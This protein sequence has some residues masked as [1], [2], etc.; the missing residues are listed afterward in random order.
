M[1]AARDR[2]GSSEGL[3]VACWAGH[4][5]QSHNHNDVGNFIVFVDGRP[6]II[7]IGKPTYTRQTFSADRYEIRS[8]QSAYHNLPTVNGAMQEAGRRYA[9]RAV[10]YESNED[11]A[12]LR[13]DIAPAYPDEAGIETW[14]RTVRL[15]R[16]KEIQVVDLFELKEKSRDI[17]Q[18][19][20]TPCE[21]IRDEPGKLV[22]RDPEKQT[23][24]TVQYDS[25]RLAVQIE[26]IR[27]D[28]DRLVA[29]WGPRL[30]RVLLKSKSAAKRDTWTL[31]FSK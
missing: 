16:G 17:V 11:Q 29:I 13:M 21:I 20:I 8:M 26:T 6:F 25:D 1:M 22:L 31:R 2:Q 9:A 5:G 7:D 28:D 3:Y 12:Q 24:L 14:L 4:N 18:N 23:Q 27:S 15:N 30:Y 10:K 19:L